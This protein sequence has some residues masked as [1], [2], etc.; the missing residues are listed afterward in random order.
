MWVHVFEIWSVGLYA[1][2]NV[3]ITQVFKLPWF[4]GFLKNK[5]NARVYKISM[6]ANVKT[7]PKNH[8]GISK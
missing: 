2:V 3:Y 4:M 1:L 6:N 5:T 7:F 8:K